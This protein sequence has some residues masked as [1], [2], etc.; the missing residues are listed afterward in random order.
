[1][2]TSPPLDLERLF[3]EHQRD[4][5]AM[6]R[7]MVGCHDTAADLAQE[8]YL[9]L[10]DMPVSQFIVSPRAFLF[11][12]AKNLALDHFRKQKFRGRQAPLEEA[13]ALPTDE[14]SAETQVYNKQRVSTLERTL[15]ELPARTQ[16]VFVLRRVYGYSY[17]EIA[18]RLDMSERAVEKHLVK[19]MTRCQ[20]A[21]LGEEEMRARTV[22]GTP[23]AGTSWEEGV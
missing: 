8:T 10:A 18:M 23:P 16:S 9:R 1:M 17:R 6:L 3:H 20:E 11:R 15:A 22:G 5:L 12:T 14:V 19:A 13:E 21:L 2:S 7:R 4:L